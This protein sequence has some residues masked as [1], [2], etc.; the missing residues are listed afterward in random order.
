MLHTVAV[1]LIDG[2]APFEFGVVCEVFGIDRTEDGVPPFDFRVCT[3][4][5]GRPV[6]AGVGAAMTSPFG[7]DQLERADLVAVPAYAIRAEYPPELLDAL[8]AAHARGAQLLTV[9]SGAFVLADAGLLDGRRCTTHW[10]H[11]EEFSRRFPLARIDPDVLY[12]DDGQ[13]ITSAGTAAGIDAALHLVRRELGSEA[14]TA[15]ARRMVVPP[16]REG[17]QRQ[18]IVQP[19]PE[20]VAESLQPL[21][22]WLSERLDTDHSVAEMARRAHMSERTFAR[23]FLAET[24]TTP[25][26]WLAAQRVLHARRLLEQSPLTV[27]EIARSAGFQTAAMLR[28]H[29]R[30]A[31]GVSPADYRRSFTQC[32]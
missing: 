15:I 24:G 25:G 7:F 19:V 1:P 6:Q 31:V 5:P 27:E 26:R 12:V 32:P 28:H 11:A 4:E 17:G 13:I 29:F 21:L 30:R 23:R 20:R 18:F 8:R 2:F 10:R 9:C 22:A 3:P 16:Q 14:A